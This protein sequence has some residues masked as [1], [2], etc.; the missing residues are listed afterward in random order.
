M[1]HTI[2]YSAVVALSLSLCSLGLSGCGE[3]ADSEPADSES[4]TE[5][6]ATDG[7]G[8]K[9]ADGSDEHADHDEDDLSNI[10]N[11]KVELAKLSPED[12]ASAEKQHICPVSGD[13]LGAMGAP[14]KVDVNG[15]Q[16]WICCGSCRDPLLENPDE[17]LAKFELD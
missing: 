11:I 4:A 8:D 15:Q 16:V 6:A 9:D 5:P 7:S 3:P 10:E 12:A 14:T 13:M 17:Y 2:T 1:K